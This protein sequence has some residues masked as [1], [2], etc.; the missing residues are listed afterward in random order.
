MPS[1]R[2]HIGEK[3][4]GKSSP[5]VLFRPEIRFDQIIQSQIEHVN[6]HS[7]HI[8]NCIAK[9]LFDT[10]NI[11]VNVCVCHQNKRMFRWLHDVHTYTIY[12][13]DTYRGSHSSEK[14]KRLK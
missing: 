9:L 6:T 4:K 11:H 1:A 3:N 10:K 8:M 13:A 5:N 2:V 7:V 14:K 12:S